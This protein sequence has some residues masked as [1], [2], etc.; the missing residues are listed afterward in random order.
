MYICTYICIYK[1]GENEQQG[2]RA[3]EL[4]FTLGKQ[5]LLK[6]LNWISSLAC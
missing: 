4:E 3:I 5:Q 6:G 1:D 2:S